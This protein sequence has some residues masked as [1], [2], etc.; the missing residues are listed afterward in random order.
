M[1]LRLID[2]GHEVEYIDIW[3]SR[4]PY[5][6]SIRLVDLTYNMTVKYNDVG[7]FYTIDLLTSRG[8]VLVFGDPVRYG[9]AMFNSFEDE[10]F[11]LPVI[12][13]YCL[14]ADDISEVTPENIGDAV[15]LY[16]HDRPI[17]GD[18]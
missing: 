10:R 12:M 6:F 1:E 2:L 14:T 8:E 9:R 11:P 4:V 15:R 18:I 16:L 3:P 17:G 13:P 5:S 7:G